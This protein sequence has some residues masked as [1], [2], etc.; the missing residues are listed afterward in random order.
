MI[1]LMH[2]S[3]TMRPPTSGIKLS[4]CRSCW[5]G[6]M[7]SS[8][9]CGRCRRSSWPR[10]WT[11]SAGLAA[12]T[13][14]QY[15]EWSTKA[16]RQAPAA[17]TFVGDIYMQIQRRPAHGCIPRL[18]GW[19]ARRDVPQRVGSGFTVGRAAGVWEA[20]PSRCR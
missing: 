18:P 3:K 2:S 7:S 11:I 12:K 8:P 16:E 5:I 17:A 20:A 10:S 14:E 15:A 9:I 1:I 19:A 13:Q 4:G 6:P